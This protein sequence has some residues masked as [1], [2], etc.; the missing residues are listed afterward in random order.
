MPVE[1]VYSTICVAIACWFLGRADN[2]PQYDVVIYG[3]T[4]AGIVCAVQ[5]AKQCPYSKSIT[6]F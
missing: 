3:G 2:A 6:H 1:K 5:L 4:S